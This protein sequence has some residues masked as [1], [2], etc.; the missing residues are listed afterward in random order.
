MLIVGDK[1]AEADTVSVRLHTNVDLRSMPVTRLIERVK[2]A[3]MA[4][5]MEL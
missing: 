1:E 5:S 2:G 3:T 4:K